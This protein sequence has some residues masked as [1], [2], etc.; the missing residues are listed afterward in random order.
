MIKGS[1][2]RVKSKK[3]G[4]WSWC[5]RWWEDLALSSYE[6]TAQYSEINLQ[7]LSIIQN[8]LESVVGLPV[9]CCSWASMAKYHL[10]DR[11]ANVIKNGWNNHLKKRLVT[12]SDI[13]WHRLYLEQHLL[14][15]DETS[16]HSVRGDDLKALMAE[17][18]SLIPYIDPNAISS[19]PEHM[20][21]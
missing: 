6:N 15:D 4:V 19:I 11:S 7:T 12:T 14:I 16:D 2:K 17:F 20:T 13:K 9:L 18:A 5:S 1:I 8:T 3:I 21:S 10:P